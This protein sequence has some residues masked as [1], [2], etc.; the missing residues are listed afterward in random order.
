MSPRAEPMSTVSRFIAA[1]PD[2][3]FAVLADGWSYTNWVVGTSHIRA[4]DASWPAP[5][6]KLHH[7]IGVW[8]LLTRDES[9]V[10]AVAPGSSLTLLARGWP[11]GAARVV[12]ELE[13]EADGTRVTLS[14]CPVAGPGKWLHNPASEALLNRRN[15]E[16]LARLAALVERRTQPD[17]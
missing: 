1:S 16:S 4:V 8:P 11:I 17:P 14:E 2:Q 9:V 13:A 10:E 6:S 7:A 5:G 3:V 12:V 15:E